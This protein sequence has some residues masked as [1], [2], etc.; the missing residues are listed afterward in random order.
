MKWFTSLIISIMVLTGTAL[1]CSPVGECKYNTGQRLW[2]YV[3]DGTDLKTPETG[4]VYTGV[5]SIGYTKEDG[6]TGTVTLAATDCVTLTDGD[7]CEIDSTNQPGLYYAYEGTT[8]AFNTKGGFTYVYTGTGHKSQ[9]Y[10]MKVVSRYSWEVTDFQGKL[11]CDVTGATSGTSITLGSNCTDHNGETVTITTDSFVGDYFR[12]YTNSST[13][14][15][16]VGE[17]ALVSDM[18]SGGVATIQTGDLAGSGF[19]ATPNT[20]N[21]GVIVE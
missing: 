7:W 17:G 13:Q 10:A 19:S 18:T 2:F 12:M 11:Y 4:I 14:C 8:T 15:N 3:V 1:A 5:T 6:S 21:C 16:V 9:A 20:T